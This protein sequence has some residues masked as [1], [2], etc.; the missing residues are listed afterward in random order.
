[1]PL[2][3]IPAPLRPLTGGQEKVRV[4]GATV[5]AAIDEL[6][7]LHPGIKARLCDAQGLRPGIAVAIDTDLAGRGLL[8][9]VGDNSEVHFL[10]ALSGG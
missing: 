3:W 10:P 2:V 9:P 6:E 4:P 7:R 1:M 5:G 8:Q